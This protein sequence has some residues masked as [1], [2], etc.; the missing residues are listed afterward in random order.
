[1]NLFTIHGAIVAPSF[2]GCGQHL[3]CPRVAVWEL[4]RAQAGVE[5]AE[6]LL[7]CASDQAD[8]EVNPLNE[9]SSFP[10]SISDEYPQLENKF[11]ID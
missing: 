7:N 11:V 1:M 9:F 3:H 8:R 10:G 4:V 6:E 2:H 5:G